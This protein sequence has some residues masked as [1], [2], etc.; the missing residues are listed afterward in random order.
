MV[1][2]VC[3]ERDPLHEPECLLEILEFEYAVQISIYHVL[4]IELAQARCNFLFS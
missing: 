2:V 3:R 4:I 1:Q